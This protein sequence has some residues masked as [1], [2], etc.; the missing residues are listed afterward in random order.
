[1]SF[2]I[3][4]PEFKKI[5]NGFILKP[6]RKISMLFKGQNNNAKKFFEV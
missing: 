5:Y 3:A 6:D 2:E 1:M 4:F